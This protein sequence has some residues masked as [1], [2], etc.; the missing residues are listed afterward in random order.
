MV[1]G[2]CQG[3]QDVTVLFLFDI[4]VGILGWHIPRPT[5][6]TGAN[7]RTWPYPERKNQADLRMYLG[8]P[9]IEQ[10]LQKPACAAV[11]VAGFYLPLRMCIRRFQSRYAG[12]SRPC[13]RRP[14]ML[15]RA[16]R[17]ALSYLRVRPVGVATPG[18]HV[19]FGRKPSFHFLVSS[20]MWDLR[21]AYWFL[22][23]VL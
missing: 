2:L 16:P 10:W 1:K 7:R 15:V 21:S 11:C 4:N 17:A 13:L 18:L 19:Q 22:P 8:W 20:L 14:L 9:R 5:P 23:E 3:S 6:Q 12:Q